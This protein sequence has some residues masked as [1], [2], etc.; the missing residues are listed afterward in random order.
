MI[1]SD[2]ET[3]VD[4]LNYEAIARTIVRVLT[5]SPETPVTIGVHGDW[6]AGK[7][8][9]LEM[10]YSQLED[11]AADSL[12]IKFNAW[13]LQG[14]ED[15]KL[16]IVEDIVRALEEARSDREGVK[17]AVEKL[18]KRIDWLKAAKKVGGVAW[19]TFTG[20]PSGDQI[21]GVRAYLEKIVADSST[22]SPEKIGEIAKDALSV[23]KPQ[24]PAHVPA[25]V[26]EFHDEFEKL[27]KA[28]GVSQLIVL[29]DDLDRCLPN[30]AIETLEAIRLFVLLPR[31]AYVIAVDEAMIEY[32][33]RQHFPELPESSGPLTYARNYLEKLIQVPFRIPALGETETRIFVTLLLLSR[34]LHS[35]DKVFTSLIGIARKK[36]ARPWEAATIDETDLKAVLDGKELEPAAKASL[37]LS[38]KIGPV[39]AR[40]TLG[41]P[42]QIKRFLNALVLRESIAIER[43]F[44]GMINR[45][46]LAKVML[47]ERF[48]SQFFGQIERW[49]ASAADGKCP[50]LSVLEA[51]GGVGEGEKGAP[52]ESKKT[53][54]RKN[55]ITFGEGGQ[56]KEVETWLDDDWVRDWISLP[57][58]L[59]EI[60][61]RPYLFLVRDTRGFVRDI[62]AL[63]SLEEIGQRLLSRWG[64]RQLVG[65]LGEL[66]ASERIR[67]FNWLR[68]RFQQ[69]QDFKTRPDSVDG[70]NALASVDGSIQARLIDLLENIPE[71]QFGPWVATGWGSTFTDMTQKTR[72]DGL[73]SR[74][75]KSSNKPLATAAGG[76]IQLLNRK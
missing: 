27:L 63:G 9:V 3:A 21:E 68:D 15:A 10:V 53:R 19:L 32:A 39:L 60:D 58:P 14:F 1:I 56:S 12:C 6:G 64:A 43:G 30:V 74:W 8:S 65:E 23:L 24:S 70:M 16:V 50:Q 7:S 45:Q 46:A 41:N 37:Q 75:A 34:D 76:Q 2:Q 73:L 4:L 26:K 40:G 62:T 48:H 29:V 49:I 54:K 66:T 5:D 71:D 42:R 59:A 22:I 36:L 18:W 17:G 61:L 69:S 35:D 55:E 33:V 13:R 72:F 57:P 28:A 51:R 31:T 20:M 67:L 25:E 47:A 38:H 11:Q 44:E 52:K